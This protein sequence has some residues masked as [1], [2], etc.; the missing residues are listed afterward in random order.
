MVSLC[1]NKYCVLIIAY[2]TR[3]QVVYLDSGRD[4]KKKNYEPIRRVLNE[5]LTNYSFHGGAMI[6][7]YAREGKLV[8]GHKTDFK[9]VTQPE[10]SKLDAYYVLMLIREFQRDM[11]QLE[12]PRHLRDLLLK[13]MTEATDS[14][15]RQQFVRIQHSIAT[16]I[17]QDVLRKE[18][19]FWNGTPPPPNADVQK[20]CEDQGDYRPFTLNGVIP[21][22]P[23]PK[24]S[25]K[26]Q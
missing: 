5:A 20:R 6:K 17:K 9:S 7:Q 8:F 21:F 1:R 4:H 13:N 15:H 14:E 11:Q 12:W 26:K 25:K 16:T 24:V 2:P 22:P 18:G 10:H 23:K 19:L 3:S